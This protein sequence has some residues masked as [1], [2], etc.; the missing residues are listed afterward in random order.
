MGEY[1]DYCREVLIE[2]QNDWMLE[3]VINP[4][5]SVVLLTNNNEKHIERCLGSLVTQT[6]KN[7][8]IIILDNDSTD[9]TS[10][11][12]NIFKKD[13]RIN[14]INCKKDKLEFNYKSALQ[15]VKSDYVLVINPKC[16]LNKNYILKLKTDNNIK[17]LPNINF[18]KSLASK[19]FSFINPLKIEKGTPSHICYNFGG[20]KFRCLKPE[21]KKERK[22]IAD[23]YQSFNTVTEIPKAEGSLRI[24]QKANA[25]FLNRFNQFCEKNNIQYWLDFGTLLG[26]IRHSGFI[27]WDDDLDIAMLRSDYER[28]ISLLKDGCPEFP[29]LVMEFENN[30]KTKCFIKISH[31]FSENLFIDI[32]PYDYYHSKLEDNEKL[33]LSLKIAKVVKNNKYNKCKKLD[34]IRTR[35]QSITKSVILDNIIVNEKNKPALFMGID[36]P[37]KW[38]NKVYDFD[39]IF[40]LKKIKFEQYEFPAPQK[41]EKV[42]SSIYGDYMSIPKD[43]YPRHSSYAKL[44]SSEQK[45]LEELA[46]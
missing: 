10:A 34:E 36:F 43:S 40:P 8:E 11:I 3:E 15:F 46:Q 25:G 24:I 44:P 6:Y 41:S 19:I 27:P 45:I 20:I 21:I 1:T 18:Y 16:N 5:Y 29:E 4:S 26:A 12:L 17:R 28:T 23:F 37:H 35:F 2:Y 39:T 22:Q 33:E 9:F 42:L 31:K 32:F 13:K 14:I 7:F 38:K 30:K